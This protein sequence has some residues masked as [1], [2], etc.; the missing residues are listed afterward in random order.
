MCTNN[1]V[2][3]L[4]AAGENQIH[5]YNLGTWDEVTQQ[6]IELPKSAGTVLRMEWASNGQLLVI[7]TTNGHVYGYLTSIP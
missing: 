6:R 1:I 5:L 7:S 4:A 3:K 2:Y